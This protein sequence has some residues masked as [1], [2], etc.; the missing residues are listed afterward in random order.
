VAPHAPGGSHWSMPPCSAVCQG[1]LTVIQHRHLS[2][3]SAGHLFHPMRTLSQNEKP[4][5]S[6]ARHKKNF[7][8]VTHPTA[9]IDY[10]TWQHTYQIANSYCQ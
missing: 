1:S 9:A 3:L 6:A 2:L 8:F 10:P 5:A 4:T 7:I